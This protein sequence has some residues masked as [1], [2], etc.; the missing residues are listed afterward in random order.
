MICLTACG[1]TST[2]SVSAAA[3]CA[4]AEHERY[5]SIPPHEPSYSEV[6]AKI[7]KG[8]WL[9]QSDFYLSEHDENHAPFTLYIFQNDKTAE[10]ALKLIST[11]P[12]AHEEWGSGGTWRRQNL[13]ITNGDEPGSLSVAAETLLK[14][15]TGAGAS[16][17]VLRPQEKEEV[18]DGRT[19]SE[20]TRAEAKGEAL[21]G[22][23]SG[24]AAAPT[25]A[26]QEP[27]ASEDHTNPGS[28]PVPGG[29]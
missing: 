24:E 4:H 27:P 5:T 28:S 12:D 9:I 25:E 1:S 20:I 13:I 6:V 2:I 3:K 14:K 26:A 29:E 10:E 16:Q 7:V 21:L 23:T 18:V 22:R 19:R 17:S 11:A 15:C 8:G